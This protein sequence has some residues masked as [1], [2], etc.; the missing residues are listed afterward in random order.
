MSTRKYSFQ[1]KWT[2]EMIH[3]KTI[4]Y[5]TCF[6]MYIIIILF[7]FDRKKA[8]TI[9]P[10]TKVIFQSKWRESVYFNFLGQFR[11]L[12][13]ARKCKCIYFRGT[14][15]QSLKWFCFGWLV[16][17]Q[18]RIVIIIENYFLYYFGASLFG[19]ANEEYLPEVLWAFC[20]FFFSFN[21]FTE[22]VG[23]RIYW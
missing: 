1:G 12:Q 17:K 22:N 10:C 7:Q 23:L 3:F 20:S 2:F 18:L 5:L 21:I 11:K 16:L 4:R 19:H 13:M 14:E 6:Y 9:L 15:F 8:K